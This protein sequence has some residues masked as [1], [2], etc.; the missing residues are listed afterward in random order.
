MSE[1]E[2]DV[3]VYEG[4]GIEEGNAKVP[5]WYIG[6]VLILV[7][8]L[9]VYLTK[10]LVGVQPSAAEMKSSRQSLLCLRSPLQRT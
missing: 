6:V 2:H 4:P 10:Y 9:A 7:G 8:F 5:L 3:H 1:H